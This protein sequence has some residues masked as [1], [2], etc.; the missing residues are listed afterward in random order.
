MYLSLSEE[1]G[2][3]SGCESEERERGMK[4]NCESEE[5][6]SHVVSR[7]N[8]FTLTVFTSQVM[9]AYMGCLFPFHLINALLQSCMSTSH[10]AAQAWSYIQICRFGVVRPDTFA[11][12]VAI[13]CHDKHWAPCPPYRHGFHV[14]SQPCLP[15]SPLTPVFWVA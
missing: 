1:T 14:S 8:S 12:S 15:S 3:K 7:R 4:S 9:S 13:L 2:K 5:R 11:V 6:D 10:A